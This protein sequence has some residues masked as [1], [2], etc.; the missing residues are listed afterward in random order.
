M[1]QTRR[2]VFSGYASGVSCRIRRPE[3][4]VLPVQAATSLPVSG[5]FCC[6]DTGPGS[7]LRSSTGDEYV[8]FESAN[9]S[10]Q[11]DFVDPKAALEMRR[12]GGTFAAPVYTNAAADVK[13]LS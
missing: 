4:V 1:D 9:S 5:G 7:L 3:D 8:T 6:C 13:G 11:G 12:Y 2:F 10:V